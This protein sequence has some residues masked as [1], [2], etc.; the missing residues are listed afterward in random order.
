MVR[1][2]NTSSL[3]LLLC[4]SVFEDLRISSSTSFLL[5]KL[6]RG[7]HRTGSSLTFCSSILFPFTLSGVRGTFLSCP[8]AGWSHLFALFLDFFVGGR[9]EGERENSIAA[10]GSF[11][12]LCR[13][14]R[15]GVVAVLSGGG[16]GV[17]LR[18]LLRF[19]TSFSSLT[20]PCSSTSLLCSRSLTFPSRARLAMWA[21]LT[22]SMAL[23]FACLSCSLSESALRCSSCSLTWSS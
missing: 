19:S 2:W 6:L 20:C 1:R 12:P 15:L 22:I 4:P 10:V 23:L 3:P 14:R 17:L 8:G 9:E 13:I 18:F 5:R 11:S 16:L 21:D 7:A